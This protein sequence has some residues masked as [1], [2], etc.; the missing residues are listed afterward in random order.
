MYIQHLADSVILI[1]F[2]YNENCYGLTI[3]FSEM[4]NVSYSSRSK[5]KVTSSNL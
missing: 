2:T 1:P 5:I 4:P 3:L